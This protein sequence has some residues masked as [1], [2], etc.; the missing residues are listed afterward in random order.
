MKM[1]RR[2]RK[3]SKEKFIFKKVFVVL[4]MLI[5][6]FCNI[7]VRIFFLF[8]NITCYLGLENLVVIYV[9][10]INSGGV[11]CLENLVIILVERENVVVV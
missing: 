1:R 11:F 6:K 9:D 2:R 3:R 10:I 4:R 7:M 5:F 8:F